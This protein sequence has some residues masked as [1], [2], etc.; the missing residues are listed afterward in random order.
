MSNNNPRPTELDEQEL[1]ETAR[2]YR[3]L[4]LVK[5]I[6]IQKE[7]DEQTLQEEWWDQLSEYNPFVSR[8]EWRGEIKGEPANK[9]PE[10]L[11]AEL[12]L[13]S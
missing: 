8:Y 9:D 3:I 6:R 2:L 11:F 4:R 7:K 12:S 13:G 1:L 5:G 10:A